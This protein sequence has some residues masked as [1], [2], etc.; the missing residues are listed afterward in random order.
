MI[1]FNINLNDKLTKIVSAE[2]I[3]KFVTTKLC[4]VSLCT[5]T[6]RERPQ[7]TLHTSDKVYKSQQKERIIDINI[8]TNLKGP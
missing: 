2:A 1:V 5:L 4:F 7:T 8:I 6:R 3:L